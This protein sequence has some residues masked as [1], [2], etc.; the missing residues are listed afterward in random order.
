MKQI[1]IIC[2]NIIIDY[3]E[4][5]HDQGSVA[6]A[7]RDTSVSS[8]EGRLV[9]D[10]VDKIFLLE[11]NKHPLVSLLTNVGKTYQGGTW[12][13]SSV[14]KK[15]TGNPEF[16]WHEDQYGG[17]YAKVSGTYSASGG[18]TITV[19]GAGSSSGY[20]FTVGDVVINARTGERMEVATIAS[21]TTI[22]IAAGGRS[23]G[24]TAAT[25]GADADGLFIV[26][27]ASEENSSARNI[28][29]TRSSKESN[30]TLRNLGV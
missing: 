11:Q 28:N 20:I 12:K 14:M 29:T 26:G 2:D 4:G 10:T 13:G 8:A 17:R 19:S 25:A 3:T 18:V 27:N 9:V 6:S 1:E 23:L 24:A 5:T 22:T 16:S 15:A 7:A 21:S 30:Y